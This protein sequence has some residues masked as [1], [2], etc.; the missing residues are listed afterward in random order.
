MNILKK[1]FIILIVIGCFFLWFAENMSI[2]ANNYSQDIEKLADAMQVIDGRVEEW[3]L[4][5]RERKNFSTIKEFTHFVENMQDKFPNA[6][7]QEKRENEQLIIKAHINGTF[8]EEL[9]FIY[10]DSQQHATVGF[11]TYELRGNQWDKVTLKEVNKIV[12]GRVFQLFSGNTAF[13]TC[14]KGSINDTLEEV[15]ENQKKPLLSILNGKEME[16]LHEEDFYSISIYSEDF[17]QIVP[18]KGQKKMNVQIGLR[19]DRMG[20]ETS[21]VIGTPIITIEY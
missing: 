9:T 20:Y 11:I 19:E 3:S 4:F 1:R 6:E 8:T 10:N 7:W 17:E 16:V 12:N 15:L 18:L 5:T 14:L 13:F 2:A 21:V